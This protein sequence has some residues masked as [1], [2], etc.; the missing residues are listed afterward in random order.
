LTKL[1][2]G[3]IVSVALTSLVLAVAVDNVAFASFNQT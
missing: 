3:S 2:I 1:A